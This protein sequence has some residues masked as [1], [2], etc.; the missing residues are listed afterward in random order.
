MS[1]IPSRKMTRGVTVLA[2]TTGT[3]SLRMQ[4]CVPPSSGSQVCFLA[5][6]MVSPEQSACRVGR[7]SATS[8]DSVTRAE[9][10]EDSKIA[11]TVLTVVTVWWAGC[12]G[13]I[14][15]HH[16][17]CREI[18]S[19]SGLAAL[20]VSEPPECFCSTLPPY[21]NISCPISSG[22]RVQVVTVLSQH[23]LEACLPA[24]LD[25]YVDNE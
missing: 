24:L 6:F 15:C 16:W 22:S 19:R 3:A 4:V 10:R 9:M 23:F 2:L 25:A 13:S 14:R 11:G 12:G 1:E 20:W 5:P 8:H 18:F 7:S 21:L 17:M